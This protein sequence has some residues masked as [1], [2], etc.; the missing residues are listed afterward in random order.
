MVYEMGNNTM[1]D[2]TA[3]RH[4]SDTHFRMNFHKRTLKSWPACEH[5]EICVCPTPYFRDHQ[6]VSLKKT[7]SMKN[8]LTTWIQITFLALGFRRNITLPNPSWFPTRYRSSSPCN[9]SGCLAEGAYATCFEKFEK[10]MRMINQVQQHCCLAPLHAGDAEAYQINFFAASCWGL[11]V[12]ARVQRKADSH[13]RQSAV[14][15]TCVTS[16]PFVHGHGHTTIHESV[17]VQH[18]DGTV[19]VCA[20]G[21]TPAHSL[22]AKDGRNISTDIRIWM[23]PVCGN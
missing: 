4:S 14:I 9:P 13:T 20:I 12:H 19:H 8:H 10:M 6:G 5:T 23:W 2:E 16:F 21:V 15:Q 18:N 7:Q 3:C 11:N 17:V 1:D 22:P